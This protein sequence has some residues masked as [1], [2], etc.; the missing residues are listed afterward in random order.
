MTLITQGLTIKTMVQDAASRMGLPEPDSV[1]GNPEITA[2]R[3]LKMFQNAGMDLVR[4]H[5]WQALLQEHAFTTVAAET[6]TG[7]PIPADFDRFVDE[8]IY[9]RT[10]TRRVLGPM[11]ARE[12][13]S[14]QALT[15]APVTDMF[16]IRGGAFLYYPAPTSG[17]TV[18]YEYVSRFW[19]DTA[20]DGS[21][22]AS[23]FGADADVILLDEEM[24]TQD[25]IWRYRRSTGQS[26][27]EDHRDAQFTILN[28]IA[29]DGGK[30]TL[31]LGVSKPLGPGVLIPEGSWN[32]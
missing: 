7:T 26:Y 22:D 18:A 16:R 11:T 15:A 28:R 19:I 5:Q 24:V 9:N 31:D 25:A 3:L 21:G 27:A 14:N 13:Q 23:V 29:A 2:Q 8:S 30:K 4:R 12:W 6:Q 17:D 1:V 32:Q 10:K 20:L